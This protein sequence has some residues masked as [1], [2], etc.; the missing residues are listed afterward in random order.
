MFKKL[1]EYI[2]KRKQKNIDYWANLDLEREEKIEKI[3]KSRSDR[4]LKDSKRL[5]FEALFLLI[6]LLIVPLYMYISSHVDFKNVHESASAYAEEI[7]ISDV[8]YEDVVNDSTAIVNF[9]Q[10]LKFTSATSYVSRVDNNVG[11]R[12]TSGFNSQFPAELNFSVLANH[13]YY[14]FNDNNNGDFR[15]YMSGGIT[16]EFNIIFEPTSDITITQLFVVNTSLV[17]LDVNIHFNIIDLTQLFG[18]NNDDLTLQQA[19]ELF[20]ADYYAYDPGSVVSLS[21]L[22]SYADGYNKASSL[23]EYMPTA[24]SFISSLQDVNLPNSNLFGVIERGSSSVDI[25]TTSTTMDLSGYYPFNLVVPIGTKVSISSR[26]GHNNGNFS[27]PIKFAYLDSVGNINVI[28][29]ANITSNSG[30]NISFTSPINLQGVYI[31]IP[32]DESTSYRVT[33]WDIKISMLV[34]NAVAGIQTAYDSGYEKGVEFASRSYGVG[35]NGYN[36]IFEAGRLQ[37]VEDAGNYTFL[38]LLTSAIDVPINSVLHM[39]DFDLLGMNM[40]SFYLSLFT[41]AIIV[42]VIKLLI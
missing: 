42:F 22:N 36:Q 35:G 24:S 29:S 14:L 12:F 11:L 13:R 15:L 20:V 31:I 28:T 33:I 18:E 5:V 34:N 38:S 40:K 37:G 41:F 2:N 3:K 30:F 16:Q 27:T 26:A 17:D 6:I 23:T 9:N 32:S 7:N 39:L 25:T 4:F 10:I 8:A 19:Q 21:G 1:K